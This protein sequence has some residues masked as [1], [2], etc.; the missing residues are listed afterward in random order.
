M[1]K[2][3]N[4]LDTLQT[5]EHASKKPWISQE[6]LDLAEEK[7]RLPSKETRQLVNSSIKIYELRSRE[8][9]GETKQHGL[10]NNVNKS[11]TLMPPENPRKRLNRS[12]Q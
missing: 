9:S 6:V 10:K 4:H 3:Q 11:K 8:L 1:D 5:A 12:D 2:L 7:S